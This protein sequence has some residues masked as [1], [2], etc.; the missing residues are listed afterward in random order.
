[1]ALFFSDKL[2]S[3]LIKLNILTNDL[4][5]LPAL[6]GIDVFFSC[7][8]NLNRIS[9]SVLLIINCLLVVMLMFSIFQFVAHP[10]CQQL[11][12]TLWYEGCPGFRRRN[13]VCKLLITVTIGLM[14]P[15][16]SITYLIAPKTSVGK[17]IRKPFIKFICHSSSYI[18]FLGKLLT[19]SS[20]ISIAPTAI[21]QIIVKCYSLLM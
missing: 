7:I 1:M 18:T 17:L 20:C 10:N 6:G 19:L 11:L 2:I 21:L 5:L 4:S 16:L 3:K 14:F 13:I 15:L 12:A 9:I 8:V